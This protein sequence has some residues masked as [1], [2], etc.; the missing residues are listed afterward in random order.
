MVCRASRAL[1]GELGELAVDTAG[2]VLEGHDVQVESIRAEV[3]LTEISELE[4]LVHGLLELLGGLH[5]AEPRAFGG[6]DVLLP[7]LAVLIL[8]EV[9][10][11]VTGRLTLAAA[12]AAAAAARAASLSTAAGGAA[13]RPVGTPRLL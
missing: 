2:L 10:V 7:L 1:G 12:R 6:V 8:E 5:G 9:H 13:D 11:A 4:A 3:C